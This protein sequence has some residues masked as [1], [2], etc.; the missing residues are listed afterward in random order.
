M[1][2]DPK[3]GSHFYHQSY[4]VTTAANMSGEDCKLDCQAQM[5]EK[6]RII[7]C[8]RNIKYAAIV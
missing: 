1:S 4:Y 8:T 7:Y 3:S 5:T 2:L 6:L